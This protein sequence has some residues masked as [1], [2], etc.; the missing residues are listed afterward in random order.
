MFI[1]FIFK[2]EREM[3]SLYTMC[4]LSMACGLLTLCMLCILFIFKQDQ[5]IIT[6]S[7]ICVVRT[8]YGRGLLC[9]L[10]KLCVLC[11]LC[12]LCVY[13]AMVGGIILNDIYK[14]SGFN[15]L[16]FYL[17]IAVLTE[18][19]VI[20]TYKWGLFVYWSSL[21]NNI[22]SR[23][24][25]VLKC[26]DFIPKKGKYMT[27]ED[28]CPI[29]L[30]C[31]HENGAYTFLSCGHPFHERCINKHVTNTTGYNQLECPICRGVIEQDVKAN[32]LKM[33]S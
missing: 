21:Y 12:M 30:E 28:E 20:L 15:A 27:E 32:I 14:S 8:N 5:Q 19:C 13:H 2:R 3:M 17:L 22:L 6:L 25:L 26:G 23:I 31:M 18:M 29:C 4:D 9:V 24:K 11:M 33:A 16:L 10:C 7:A 1:I